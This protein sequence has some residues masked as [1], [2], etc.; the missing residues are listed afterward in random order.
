MY[1]D[2]RTETILRNQVHAWFKN[3]YHVFYSVNDNW[4]PLVTVWWSIEGAV[5]E[6]HISLRINVLSVYM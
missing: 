4:D 5:H 3:V 2:V 1:I 6:L